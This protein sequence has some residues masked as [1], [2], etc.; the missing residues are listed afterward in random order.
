[1]VSEGGQTGAR[2][3]LTVMFCDVVGSTPLSTVLDPEELWDILRAYQEACAEA[4][5]EYDG[6]IVHVAGDGLLVTFG[7]P[8][9]HEDDARRAVRAGLAILDSVA[10][11]SDDVARQH[12]VEFAVRVGIHTGVV[13]VAEVGGGDARVMSDLVG[14]TPNVAAR[15]QALAEPNT[16]VVSDTTLELLAGS[17]VV[18]DLGEHE[19]RGLN[20][21]IAL[22]RIDGL[23]DTD[24]YIG[25]GADARTA[26]GLPRLVGRREELARLVEAWAACAQGAGRAVIVTGPPGIGKSRLLEA[27]VAEVVTDESR[28]VALQCS[29]YQSNSVLFPVRRYIERS[30]GIAPADEATVRLDK[31]RR[32]AQ[33]RSITVGPDEGDNAEDDE[34]L[35]VLAAMLRLS[36]PPAVLSPEQLRERMFT[37]L[38][39][40]LDAMTARAPVLIT[41]EDL[42]WADPTTLELLRRVVT[43][44]P[45]AAACVVLTTRTVPDELRP[46]SDVAV[47]ELG[48]LTASES[49]VLVDDIASQLTAE[50][51][52]AVVERGDGVPLFVGELA[53]MLAVSDRRQAPGD[54][55]EVDIPPT[56]HELL[57]ARLDQLGDDRDLADVLATIGHWTPVPLLSEVT[58]GDPT[59]LAD[60][61]DA[62]EDAG[63]LRADRSGV[64]PLYAFEHV[65]LR[66]AAYVSQLRSRRRRVH[67]MVAEALEGWIRRA[68]PLYLELLA[69][70][71]EHAGENFRAAERWLESGLQAEV[72]AGHAEATSH[73]ERGLAALAQLP[74]SRERS[75]LELDITN[76]LGLALQAQRGY[77]N[78][79]VARTFA[80]ARELTIEVGAADR[81]AT[82]F[83]LWAYYSVCGKRQTSLDLARHAL[84]TA[85][86]NGIDRPAALTMLGFD[87][88]HV[89]EIDEALQRLDETEAIGPIEIAAFPHDLYA[90]VLVL[91]AHAR[92]LHGERRRS[93]ETLTA[94]LQRSEGLGARK[95]P[96][97]RAFVHSYAA[98]HCQ[99]M[100]DSTRAAVHA[101]RAL[102]I[103]FEH[104][105]ASWLGAG[106]LHLAIAN[107]HL[108]NPAEAI[109]L[110]EFAIGAWREAG[111]ETFRSYFLAGLA[112][113]Q[114]RAG[115]P[116]AALAS[117][118]EGID[119]IERFGE[120]FHEVELR[121]L[122]G[123]LL[124]A[125][126]DDE[127]GRVELWR[128]LAV[129][130]RQQARSFELRSALALQRNAVAPG[131]SGETAEEALLTAL[132]GFADDE[133]DAELAGARLRAG[134]VRD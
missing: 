3:R 118:A 31:L 62:L 40:W 22:F 92:W 72:I 68:G 97:T 120:H 5:A 82:L 46:V 12:G 10:R 53:R 89:G 87:L 23:A 42:H 121:R 50:V 96:F 15:I 69:F 77:T 117:V 34:R 48:P 39:S 78:P 126:G 21:P 112:D 109:P 83:G 128:A 81:V 4:V 20:R 113:A 132:R 94:S 74:A 45:H 26:G 111:A 24:T 130:R 35:A 84:S 105:Y 11:I 71:L 133:D 99:V 16:M 129:A 9:A 93:E 56:L 47:I 104:G 65:L 91:L 88:F 107:S 17:F 27:M 54:R 115:D 29:A 119:H 102:E 101:N 14:E 122:R 36:G 79:D 7:H 43:P 33:E 80:R 57:L 106:T 67:A 28:H 13:V 51:K 60:R 76:A 75:V 127:R 1:V 19:V 98:W 37:L 32:W 131:A 25:A 44:R 2:R 114:R 41:V 125:G 110:L 85:S 73:Y 55:S 95:G 8:R 90:A 38:M 108:E 70:H 100:G 116:A 123:E 6:T 61:L 63:I 58:G 18:A 124:I 66:D 134:L 52:Q 59:H 64:E 86:D 49:S 30:A 103:S